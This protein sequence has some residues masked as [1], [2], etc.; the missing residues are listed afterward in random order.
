MSA[1]KRDF[2]PELSHLIRMGRVFASIENM[3]RR[4]K[5]LEREGQITLAGAAQF[6]AEQ[7]EKRKLAE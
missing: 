6:V 2:S 5:A 7:E 4:A 3:N 1:E